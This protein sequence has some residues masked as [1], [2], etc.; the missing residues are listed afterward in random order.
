MLQLELLFQRGEIVFA[1]CAGSEPWPAVIMN[2]LPD[3]FIY[4]VKFYNHRSTAYI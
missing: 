3:Y 1:K 2:V 4:N